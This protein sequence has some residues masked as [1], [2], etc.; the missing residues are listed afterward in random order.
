MS[1]ID[2]SKLIDFHNKSKRNATISAVYPPG[3]FGALEI[4]GNK[5]I[6]FNE[7]PK[8]DGSLING[9]FFILS[10]SVIDLIS[11][12][13]TVWEKYPMEKL[14]STNQMSCYVHN[15]FWQSMDT[16]RDKVLLENLW[17]SGDAPWKIGSQRLKCCISSKN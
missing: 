13:D 12:D 16:L 10:P 17:N 11:N 3:R 2:I 9:G 14:A 8:G 6:K 1:N 15:G 4:S 5:V 7:K